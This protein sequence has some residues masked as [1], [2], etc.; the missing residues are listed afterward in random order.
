VTDSK[1]DAGVSRRK[2]LG[3]MG[4]TALGAAAAVTMKSSVGSSVRPL[5]SSEADGASLGS[6]TLAFSWLLDVQQA[7]SYI[8]QTR[9]YYSP[10]SV[11]FLPGGDSFA[12]EPLVVS[13]KALC[14]ETDA[15]TSAA[16]VD[17]GANVVIVGTQYQ[18][19][20]FC[21]MSLANKL[22]LKEPK[23]LIN[24]SVGY[25]P[26]MAV[27]WFAWLKANKLKT[28]SGPGEVHSVLTSRDASIL[29]S[30][31]TQAYVGWVT[32]DVLG[33]EVA[34]QKVDYLLFGNTG[35][36]LYAL[37]Y[38]V[39]RSALKNSKQR[40]QIIALMKGEIRGWEVECANQALGLS[41]TMDKY[42]KGLGLN[43]KE[44]KM[45]SNDQVTLLIQNSV[46]KKHGL[47]WMAEAD[48]EANLKSLRASN[49]KCNKN[50]FDNSL[51][52]EIYDGKAHIAL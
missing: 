20:P 16:A 3:G 49:I 5:V 35:L 38:C 17:Q 11:K 40:K 39:A 14:A 4:A 43:R 21:V 36:K 32:S 44:E 10:L 24:K 52:E 30:G 2:F 31:D 41:L 50:L 8:A 25:G 34:G 45:Q 13:G 23:D 48:I 7:G 33:L 1:L 19:N 47:F 12:G 22:K 6:A 51:L 27:P 29:T 28:G 18:T 9:K 26:N 37:T 15:T 42:G 46:T